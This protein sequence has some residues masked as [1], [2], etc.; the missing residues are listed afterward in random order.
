MRR[1]A[2]QPQ[3]RE[4][5]CVLHSCRGASEIVDNWNALGMNGFYPMQTFAYGISPAEVAARLGGRVK[6][7]GRMDTQHL[8]QEGTPD[9]AAAALRKL[10]ALFGHRILIGPSHEALLPSVNPRNVWEILRALGPFEI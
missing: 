10:H 4:M 9:D 1:F 2:G 6:F 7:W 8:L 5:D 3:R